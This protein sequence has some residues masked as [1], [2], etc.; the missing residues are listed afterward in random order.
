MTHEPSI[1]C[2]CAIG[3]Q[4]VIG[5]DQKQIE[6]PRGVFD[7]LQEHRS[8]TESSYSNERNCVPS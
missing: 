1:Q 5:Q 6:M 2:P 4:E 8:F 3:P 7:R